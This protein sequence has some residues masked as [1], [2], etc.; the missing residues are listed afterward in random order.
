[1]HFQV[2]RACLGQ[3]S[4]AGVQILEGGSDQQA[5]LAGRCPCRCTSEGGGEVGLGVRKS[6]GL[7]SS[8]SSTAGTFVSLN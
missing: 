5:G 1:M 4:G 7:E 6:W 8:L 2:Q 3:E